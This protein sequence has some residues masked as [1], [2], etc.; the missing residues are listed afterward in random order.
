MSEMIPIINP[1]G[2]DIKRSLTLERKTY[3]EKV[4]FH[5]DSCALFRTILN[6]KITF[7]IFKIALSNRVAVI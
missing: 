1:S 2:I 4:F 7:Q 3:F 6:T 5:G